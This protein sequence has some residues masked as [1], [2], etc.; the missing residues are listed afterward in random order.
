MVLAG[1]LETL[2]QQAVTHGLTVPQLI[3]HR[4]EQRAVVVVG[5]AQAPAP[6]GQTQGAQE[7]K[8]LAVLAGLEVQLFSPMV[9]AV[10]RQ[11]Q[12]A[13]VETV[14]VE[15]Q[16]ERGLMLMVVVV[17]LAGVPV[18]TGLTAEL[19]VVVVDMGR[20]GRVVVLVAQAVALE[21]REHQGRAPAVVALM[22]A[23]P[24]A[25]MDL[26]ANNG[27]LRTAQ[28]AVVAVVKHRAVTEDFTA[29]VVVVP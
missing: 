21:L 7:R 29:V 6:V 18:I 10:V 20:M 13:L 11:G 15:T 2:E 25:V 22:M 1:L 8:L 23:V 17:A 9:V 28:A 27:T 12:E 19:M 3:P 24:T 14:E 4:Q 26:R 16:P 5:S